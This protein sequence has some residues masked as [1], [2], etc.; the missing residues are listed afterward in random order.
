M[1]QFVTHAL[2]QK[3]GYSSTSSACAINWAKCA[4]IASLLD[5]QSE[6]CQSRK[7]G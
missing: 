6:Q 2:Q 3:G 1:C 5:L 4:S 7:P